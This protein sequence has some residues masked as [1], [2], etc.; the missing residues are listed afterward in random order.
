MEILANEHP[1]ERAGL[2]IRCERLRD[3][4]SRVLFEGLGIM[5]RVAIR[6]KNRFGTGGFIVAIGA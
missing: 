5:R 6:Q 2:A 3:E 4:R 1:V